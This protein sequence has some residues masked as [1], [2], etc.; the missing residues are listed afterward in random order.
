MQAGSQQLNLDLPKAA[1][2]TLSDAHEVD[3]AVESG[4]VWITLDNDPRDIILEP[5]EHFRS[6]RHERALI[7]AV[8]S[9]SV[10]FSGESLTVATQ[11]L[12][13]ARPAPN[14]RM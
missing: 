13:S 10:R 6:G 12:P 11:K 8:E 14:W 2:F 9:A 1:I 4:A 5:G 3:I 7:A